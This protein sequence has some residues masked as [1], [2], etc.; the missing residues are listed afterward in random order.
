M[1]HDLGVADDR[2][3]QV[4]EVVRDAAG[5]AADRFHLLRVAQLL[6]EDQP[7][8][9]RIVALRHDRGQQQA[10]E[11]AE[12]EEREQQELRELDR[13]RRR[14]GRCPV[15]AIAIANAAISATI[16]A[17]PRGAE[18]QAGPADDREEDERDRH[19]AGREDAPQAEHQLRCR[20]Q[21]RAAAPTPSPTRGHVHAIGRP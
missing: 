18:A 4:V 8:G 19:V 11:R 2:G 21:R 3:Q 20:E 14:T 12:R 1:Q 16:V 13:E 7:L 6:F 9:Q 10:A 5:Q 15:P 17:A